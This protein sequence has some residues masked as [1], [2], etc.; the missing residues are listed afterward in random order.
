MSGSLHRRSFDPAAKGPL[1]GVRVIDLSRLVCGNTL[2]GM[3]ADFGADVIKVE[4]RAGDTLR[5]TTK[6]GGAFTIQFLPDGANGAS[7]KGEV[8]IAKS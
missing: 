7:A 1:D 8:L 5:G 4:P 6:D 2:T 3:L